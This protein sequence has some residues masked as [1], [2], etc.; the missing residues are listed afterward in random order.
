MNDNFDPL[1]PRRLQQRARSVF[2]RAARM[3]DLHGHA[4]ALE[5]ANRPDS[6]LHIPAG[7]H[8][9]N[10]GQLMSQN[11]ASAIASTLGHLQAAA[12]SA[13]QIAV[14]DP[15]IARLNAEIN[16]ID[17]LAAPADDV[18]DVDAVEVKG[19]SDLVGIPLTSNSKDGGA[20][21]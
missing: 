11:A 14:S 1:D 3:Q 12:A 2:A 21:G 20:V 6:P 15:E 16:G 7:T 18:V 8:A 13:A 19:D 17:L 9:G 4:F 10:P 5:Q